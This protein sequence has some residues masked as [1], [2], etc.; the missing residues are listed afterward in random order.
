MC[1]EHLSLSVTDVIVLVALFFVGEVILSRLLFSVHI[2]DRPFKDLHELN[3][4]D[5]M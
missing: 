2:R 1:W 5:A 4:D 3:E